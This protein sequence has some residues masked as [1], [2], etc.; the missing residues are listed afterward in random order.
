M[1]ISLL[2]KSGSLDKFFFIMHLMATILSVSYK[3][4]KIDTNLKYEF[5][6]TPTL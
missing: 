2:S 3:S 6:S 5:Q 4:M 1:L